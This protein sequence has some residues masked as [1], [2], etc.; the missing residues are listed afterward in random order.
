MRKLVYGK[1]AALKKASEPVAV[2]LLSGGVEAEHEYGG[3]G[4]IFWRLH[5]VELM[6]VRRVG[7]VG[8]MLLLSV[9]MLNVVVAGGG[10]VG[11]WYT[12]PAVEWTEALPVGN[13][14]LFPIIISIE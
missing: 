5:G 7:E 1:K 2:F 12:G 11:L 13:G 8:L 10:P 14:P 6:F 3:D 4:V 9:V